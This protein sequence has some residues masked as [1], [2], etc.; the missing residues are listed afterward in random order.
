[1]R[2]FLNFEDILS[3]SR[4]GVLSKKV[5]KIAKNHAILGFTENIYTIY[6]VYR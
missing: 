4:E 2:M 6:I 1:M 3:A 5:K